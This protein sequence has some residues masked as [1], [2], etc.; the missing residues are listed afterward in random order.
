M[1]NCVEAQES[2]Q[3]WDYGAPWLSKTN[4]FQKYIFNEGMEDVMDVNDL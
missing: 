4:L 2:H 3:E 1:V